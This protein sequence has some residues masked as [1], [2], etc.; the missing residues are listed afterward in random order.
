MTIDIPAFF[1]FSFAWSTFFNPL[2]F[3]SYVSLDLNWFSY[4]QHMYGSC[5]LIHWAS[6]CLLIGA[7]NPFTFKVIQCV[8]SYCH[9]INCFGFVF[10]GVFPASSFVFFSFDLMVLCLDSFFFCVCVS[11]VDY[12]FA[13]TM[14]FWYSGMVYIYIVVCVCVC[15]CVCVYFKTQ[16]CFKLLIS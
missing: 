11:T 1:W 4:R 2:T 13:V 5:F 12:W 10:V 7:F 8:C 15:V 3:S 16:S 9:F 6:L 14:R